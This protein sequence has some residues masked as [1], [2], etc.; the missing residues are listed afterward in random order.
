[1]E[2]VPNQPYTNQEQTDALPPEERLSQAELALSEARSAYN[3]AIIGVIVVDRSCEPSSEANL[4]RTICS[5]Q[6]RLVSARETRDRLMN[7]IFSATSLSTF[8]A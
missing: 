2:D 3:E 6:E 1:M 8:P 4:D 7:E 5:C